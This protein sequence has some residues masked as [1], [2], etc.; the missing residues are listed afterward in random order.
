MGPNAEL[1]SIRAGAGE[2]LGGVVSNIIPY[3]VKRRTELAA[4]F[5]GAI[6]IVLAVLLGR[7][8]VMHGRL[9]TEAKAL[10]L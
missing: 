8:S 9:Q 5:F 4:W 10:K 3:Q 7:V 2:Q 1:R 6:S